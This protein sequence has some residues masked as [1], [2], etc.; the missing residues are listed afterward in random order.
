MESNMQEMKTEALL[1]LLK[2]AYPDKSCRLCPFDV[3]GHEED[4]HGQELN[5]IVFTEAAMTIHDPLSTFCGRGE[6]PDRYGMSEDHARL[7][8]LHNRTYEK[9]YLNQVPD[10]T[11]VFEQLVH[12]VNTQPDLDPVRL[13]DDYGFIS[14]HS[15]GGCMAYAL[16]LPD[17]SH[18]L[19]T[20]DDGANLPKRM[21]EAMVGRY[22]NEG[23]EI[24]LYQRQIALQ[25]GPIAGTALNA[26]M[27]ALQVHFFGIATTELSAEA[28]QQIEQH[29][30]QLAALW[31]HHSLPDG[32]RVKTEDGHTFARVRGTW[33][34]N[35]MTFDTLADIQLDFAVLPTN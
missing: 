21:G 15:G 1:A 25:L 30:K 24:Q 32:S 12:I 19:V 20:D 13:L 3:N 23:A 4:Q 18:V 33:T 31:L 5:A 17:D 6:Q 10:L 2:E 29:G 22:D 9:Y 8:R 11:H 7:L 35:D 28:M 26:F 14:W 27:E 34:D 16:F